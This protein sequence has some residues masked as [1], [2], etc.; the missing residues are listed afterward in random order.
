[1]YDKDTVSADEFLGRSI[2]P[3]SKASPSA[4]ALPP[5]EWYKLC[6]REQIPVCFKQAQQIASI[7]LY[8][9]SRKVKY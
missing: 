1:M 4:T 2:V 7:N 9:R 6:L 8:V 3:F 5:P